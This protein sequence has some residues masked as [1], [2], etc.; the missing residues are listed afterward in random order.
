MHPDDPPDHL[1][2]KPELPSE[3]PGQST[4]LS[5][6]SPPDFRSIISCYEYS[7]CFSDSTEATSVFNCL[8]DSVKPG[9]QSTIL[10]HLQRVRTGSDRKRAPEPG[11][12]NHQLQ[13]DDRICR[14][15]I[16]IGYLKK[17][18]PSFEG[19][20]RLIVCKAE[21]WVDSAIHLP[22]V[23][24]E[25]ELICVANWIGSEVLQDN[26]LKVDE[27]LLLE[28]YHATSLPSSRLRQ[29]SQ[30]HNRERPNRERHNRERHNQERHNRDSSRSTSYYKSSPKPIP[31]QSEA[32]V[33]STQEEAF[34]WRTRDV[35]SYIPSFTPTPGY[36]PH[37]VGRTHISPSSGNLARDIS[38]RDL[39]TGSRS[40]STQNYTSL[41]DNPYTS[42]VPQT[43]HNPQSPDTRLESATAEHDT[44][45]HYYSEPSSNTPRWSPRE[46]SVSP[47]SDGGEMN[48][49]DSYSSLAYEERQSASPIFVVRQR[50]RLTGMENF[51]IQR[52]NQ[53]F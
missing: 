6:T 27:H 11:T 45:A 38:G 44:L 16:S 19:I 26:S 28:A 35:Q 2:I 23:R 21:A 47:V 37:S 33:T 40:F 9:T 17:A 5:K 8:L 53:A 50:P 22:R 34:Q 32:S 25:L 20:W 51:A 13:V 4:L 18:Y 39:V 46:S 29:P 12:P 15:T 14:T 24:S 36:I 10:D 41:A 7:G 48:D 43:Y 49:I 30:R 31:I 1:V 3:Q 52:N 42:S